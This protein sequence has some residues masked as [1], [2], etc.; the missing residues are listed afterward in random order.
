MPRAERERVKMSIGLSFRKP[1]YKAQQ[2]GAITTILLLIL[3]VPS[4]W[5]GYKIG[6][7]YW[8]QF[9]IQHSV[10]TVATDAT[11][12]HGL[13]DEALFQEL[14][15]TLS[16]NDMSISAKDFSINHSITPPVMQVHIHNE[17]QLNEELKI[18]FDNVVKEQMQPIHP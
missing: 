4:G 12:S 2:G 11:F 3:L 10:Q 15:K 14:S 5:L 16:L 8:N 7:M 17:M 13:S 6:R 9:N 1:T 18:V